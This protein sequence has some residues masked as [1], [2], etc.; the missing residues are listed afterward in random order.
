MNGLVSEPREA[1]LAWVASILRRDIAHF[2]PYVAIGYLRRGE[3]VA[4]A[5]FNG[6]TGAS[7]LMH[8]A[9]VHGE[10]MPVPFVLA[11]LD[12][13]FNKAR[14]RR[15]TGLIDKRNHASRH[16]A[17]HLGARLE[18]VMRDALPDGDLCVY[19]LLAKDGRRWLRGRAL[20]HIAPAFMQAAA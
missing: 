17:E 15:I 20:R 7:I 6:Y 10:P 5:V 16:F 8:I 13:A 1:I 9:K 3:L 11:F 18:G 4:G 14:V 12:Y 19:G 2:G